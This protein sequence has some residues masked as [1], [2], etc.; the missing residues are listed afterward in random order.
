MKYF[1]IFTF[2]FLTPEPPDATDAI[3]VTS[4]HGEPLSF[5]RLEDCF[6]HAQ[7]NFVA[8]HDLIGVVYPGST[9]VITNIICHP[10]E[11]LDT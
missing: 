3:H 5:D 11:G 6:N 9:G 7:N 8:L 10:R 2:L 4:L 1:L